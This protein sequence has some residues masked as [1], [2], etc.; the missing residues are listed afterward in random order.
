MMVRPM[1]RTRA[2]AGL[3]AALLLLA[4]DASAARQPDRQA[5]GDAQPRGLQ[6]FF[7]DTEGGA[8]TLITTPAG[9]SVLIDSG[10][11]DDRDAGRIVEAA[12]Q[13]GVTEITHYITTHWHSDHVGGIGIVARTLPVRHIY[14][15]RIP[16]PLPRDIN[17]ELMATWHSLSPTPRMLAAGDTI[18]LQGRRG[19]PRPAIRVLAADGLV[20][21]EP[22]GAPH[23]VTCDDGHEAR[24]ED[25]S[26]N[27]RSLALH[28]TYG[29]FD[30][31]AGGDLTWNIE[32]KLTC[33]RRR[34]PQVDVFL[35]NHHGLDAS[36]HPA[37]IAA[38]APEV[39]VVNNG[40]RKGAEPRTMETLLKQVG[41]LGV[42]QLHRN[43]RPGAINAERSRIVNDAEACQGHPLQLRV[44][45]RGDRYTVYVPSRD[46]ERVYQSR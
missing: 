20:E 41:D 29:R 4:L 16:D 22:A 2:G 7:V 39:A 10:N 35:V 1:F 27:A 40:P 6:I 18:E 38:L 15:H 31:F 46:A 8:A 24:P 23:T 33:P 28:L 34:V 11:P 37:L 9:E 25:T 19:T 32:H 42:F 13:A 36:N 21:G 45:P 5:A 17:A 3:G 12:R 14:G 30:L 43:V 26:D 44:D